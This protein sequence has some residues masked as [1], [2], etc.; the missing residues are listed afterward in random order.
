MKRTPRS[1]EITDVLNTALE[2]M[3]REM[4]VDRDTLVNQ[5]IFSLARLH[6]FIVPT[7][8]SLDGAPAGPMSASVPDLDLTAPRRAAVA[9]SP[10]A[11]EATTSAGLTAT[12]PALAE[13]VAPT[14]T[15]DLAA[16]RALELERMAAIAKDVDALVVPVEPPPEQAD[17][18]EPPAEHTVLVRPSNAIKVWVQADDGGE[19]AVEP[20]RFV[21]GR[22]D[23]CNLVIDSL[24]VSREHALVQIVGKEVILEDLGSSNGTWYNGE[25]VDR[26]LMVNGDEVVL[27][28]ERVRFRIEA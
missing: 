3:S 14:A 15:V 9:S 21:I 4:N 1:F 7:V 24:R 18:V 20:G 22:G 26:R 17:D 23:N 2:T 11:P 6:G 28:N 12:T 16:L 27:G 8:V 19:I 10:I 25:K 13:P 5:A